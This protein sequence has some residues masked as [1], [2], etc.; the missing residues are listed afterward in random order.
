MIPGVQAMSIATWSV[1][2]AGAK[3]IISSSNGGFFLV[4]H[5]YVKDAGIICIPAC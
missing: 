4:G 2:I 3:H 1:C 5:M